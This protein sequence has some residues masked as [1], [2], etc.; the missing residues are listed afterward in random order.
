MLMNALKSD[1]DSDS[2]ETDCERMVRNGMPKNLAN[3]AI[4]IPLLDPLVTFIFKFEIYQS[5]HSDVLSRF[6]WHGLA[7][8]L[9]C[10]YIKFV[11]VSKFVGGD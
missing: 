7:F 2:R 9:L 3:P 8:A 10:K 6:V 1:A 5:P 11:A 4:D